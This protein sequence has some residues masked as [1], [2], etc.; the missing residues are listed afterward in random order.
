MFDV[1]CLKT[2]DGRDYIGKMNHTMTGIPCQAWISQTPQQHAYDDLQLFPDG[3]HSI[4]DID[5]YCRNLKVVSYDAKPWCLTMDARVR[6]QYCD[7]PL[8]RGDSQ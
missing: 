1:E 8:C 4:D 3:A 7:I 2:V 5:N 6:L